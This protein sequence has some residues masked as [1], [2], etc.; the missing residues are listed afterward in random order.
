M[1]H[2]P[3]I[4][5]GAALLAATGC[6]GVTECSCVAPHTAIAVSG[7]VVVDADPLPGAVVEARV[8]PGQCAADAMPSSDLGSTVTATDGRYETT[9]GTTRTG[10]A[11]LIVTARKYAPNLIA[12]TRRID[13]TLPQT[14]GGE[15]QR[16]QADVMATAQ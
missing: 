1:S 10:A 15:T 12:G 5:T 13:L 3:R 6:A 2:V 9:L 7:A 14:L 16:I 11:C 4:L 8:A